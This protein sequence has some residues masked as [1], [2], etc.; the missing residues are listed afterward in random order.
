ME[1][2]DIL[3]G[4]VDEDLPQVRRSFGST[5]RM[6]LKPQCIG[7]R[8]KI[9]LPMCPAQGDQAHALGQLLSDQVAHERSRFADFLCRH[10]GIVGG[11]DD[12][13]EK[14]LRVS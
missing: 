12:D 3:F 8:V 4:G 11:V 14:C 13:T 10:L 2:V 7:R 5:E 1:F 6:K 9:F